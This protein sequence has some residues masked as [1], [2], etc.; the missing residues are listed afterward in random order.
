MN[1]DLNEPALAREILQYFLRHPQAADNLEGVVRWRLMEEKIRQTAEQ[2]NH[3]LFWL[4][5]EG[6]LEETSVPGNRIFRLRDEK[7]EAAERFLESEIGKGCTE[8]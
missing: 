6:F 2:A 8:H 5:H 1:Q 3:A 7:R 4:V